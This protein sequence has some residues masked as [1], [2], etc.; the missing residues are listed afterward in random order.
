MWMPVGLLLGLSATCPAHFQGDLVIERAAE[1]PE[2]L[3]TINGDLVLG[4]GRET[5]RFPALTDVTGRLDLTLSG[6]GRARFP[7]L[8]RV[9]GPLEVKLRGTGDLGLPALTHVGGSI[10]LDLDPTAPARGL[11]R[12]ERHE[13]GL[14]L[15]AGGNQKGLLS[16]LRSVSGT[17][18][19]HPTGPLEGALPALERVG[20][21]LVLKNGSHTK[22]RGLTAL[23]AV[24]GGMY[25]FGG[26]R[27]ALPKLTRVEEALALRGTRMTSMS[28]IGSSGTT[29]GAL[30][31]RDN[32]RL[33]VWPS[34]LVV[35]RHRIEVVGSP[36][37]AAAEAQG[38]RAPQNTRTRKVA[39]NSR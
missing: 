14:W 29:V 5:L 4:T 17:V 30:L 6:R 9:H 18:F 20:G 32:G 12:L 27:L 7:R 3:E 13:A 24:E 39:T 22:L 31:L 1:I 37:L 33:K 15:F 34:H 36:E 23:R 16:N 26:E 38:R 25:V 28:Q 19:L 35:P 10:G 11:V 2:C 21:H 8:E